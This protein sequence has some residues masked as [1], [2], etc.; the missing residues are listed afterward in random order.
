MALIVKGR[1]TPYQRTGSWDEFECRYDPQIT[2]EQD[3]QIL[4][5]WDQLP[6]P[7]PESRVWTVV[8]GDN[9]RDMYVIPGL[10]YVNRLGYILCANHRDG[11]NHKDYRYE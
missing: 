9:G 2:N 6:Q 7:L 5:N 4:H 10:H 8:T 11:L 1:E 3:A